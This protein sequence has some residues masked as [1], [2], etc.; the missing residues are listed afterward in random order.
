MATIGPTADTADTGPRPSLRRPIPAEMVERGPCPFDPPQGLR[1]LH[2]RDPISPVTLTN[3]ARAW[4]V[5]GYDE[6]RAIFGDT[7]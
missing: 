3:G 5:T 2:S 7:R 1:V 6:A 4:V